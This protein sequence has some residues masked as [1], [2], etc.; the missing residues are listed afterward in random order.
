[1]KLRRTDV[2]AAPLVIGLQL[3]RCLFFSWSALGAAE[4]NAF[5]GPD[6]VQL[7]TGLYVLTIPC[8]R[9]RS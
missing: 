2:L 5:P 7:K 3:M 8:C 1:M 9:G 6:T 4:A